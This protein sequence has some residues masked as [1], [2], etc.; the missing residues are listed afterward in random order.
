MQQRIETANHLAAGLT[1]EEARN[2]EGAAREFYRRALALMN[3]TGCSYQ[4][5]VQAIQD[6]L[7]KVHNDH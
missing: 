4:M 2:L 6:T 7:R 5:A 1:D 3:E